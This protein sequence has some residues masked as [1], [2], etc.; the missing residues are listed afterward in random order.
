MNIN[1]FIQLFI[2]EKIRTSLFLTKATDEYIFFNGGSNGLY[3]TD[4]NRI[5]VLKNLKTSKDCNFQFIMDE[6]N[7]ILSYQRAI[8]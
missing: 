7:I 3:N 5:R 8:D 2:T 4:T 1:L 6:G